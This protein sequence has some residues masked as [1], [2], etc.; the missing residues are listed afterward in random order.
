MKLD[1]WV[2]KDALREGDLHRA[3]CAVCRTFNLPPLAPDHPA[4]RGAIVSER[5][6][7][8]VPE[9]IRIVMGGRAYTWIA[10][11]NRIWGGEGTEVR[12]RI[13]TDHEAARLANKNGAE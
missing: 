6:F 2:I 8:T 11:G 1:D 12:I 9:Q 13:W 3:V 4:I 10:S 5:L 7:Q